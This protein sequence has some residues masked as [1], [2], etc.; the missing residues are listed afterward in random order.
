MTSRGR[1]RQLT[2]EAEKKGLAA[3][4]GEGEVQ[5]YN[6]VARHFE[7]FIYAN[8]LE[9]DRVAA[10][11]SAEGRTVV[12]CGAGPSLRENA[13]AYC[14]DE[15]GDDVDVWGINSAAGWL[16]DNGLRLTHAFTVDQTP[17][18][19]KEWVNCWP[20]EYLIAS[21]CHPHLTTYLKRHNRH[22]TFFHNFVGIAKPPVVWEDTDGTERTIDY[23]SWL[24]SLLYDPTVRVGAGLNGTTR[25]VDLAAFMGYDRIV[26]LGADCAMVA[27][28]LIPPELERGTAAHT[29]WMEENTLF[30]ADGGSAVTNGQ[31]DLLFQGEIDGRLW[32]TKP[33][34]MITAIQL[35]IWLRDAAIPGL[36]VIGDTLPAVL[37]EKDDSFLDR[38]PRL[39]NMAGDPIKI[40]KQ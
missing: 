26:V 25:A 16:W 10:Q 13:A 9:C 38:L 6:P 20:V 11:G 32:S 7:T 22:V 34:L 30:H 14:G 21:S 12:I 37:A 5:L 1:R 15:A 40:P 27:T 31:S 35:G 28:G 4:P 33:D 29:A 39:S 8:A 24:Y 3:P 36:E 18:L 17:T 19:L 2:R 23:E